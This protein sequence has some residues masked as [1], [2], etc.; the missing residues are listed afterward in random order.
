MK[1]NHYSNG[2]ECSLQN[3]K[4][5]FCSAFNFKLILM[6]AVQQVEQ[7]PHQQMYDVTK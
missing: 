6:V 2:L 3:A 7:I 5:V 1:T 4:E